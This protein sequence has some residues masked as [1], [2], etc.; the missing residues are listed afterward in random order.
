MIIINE[1]SQNNVVFVPK[2]WQPTGA[3][4]TFILRSRVTNDEFSFSVEDL[5][6]LTDYFVFDI[7]AAD[8][9]DGE[10]EYAVHD[11]TEKVSTGLLRVG[12]YEV[13]KKEYD[14]RQEY[15]Q[16]D[17]FTENNNDLYYK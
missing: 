1:K 16:Y 9:S 17:P 11:E 4:L 5:S 12:D 10:Y 3:S 2:F 6:G 13:E 15:V 7:N 14:Y 8:L